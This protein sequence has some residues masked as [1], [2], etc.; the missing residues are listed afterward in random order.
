MSTGGGGGFFLSYT[1]EAW[2]EILC[3]HY[4]VNHF[5]QE[6][7]LAQLFHDFFYSMISQGSVFQ[8][9]VVDIIGHWCVTCVSQLIAQWSISKGRVTGV[10]ELFYVAINKEFFNLFFFVN[11]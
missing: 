8:R 2:Y 10:R 7:M 6:W 9:A 3:C 1:A 4:W 11:P 5:R